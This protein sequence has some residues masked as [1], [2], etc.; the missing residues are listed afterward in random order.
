MDEAIG[1]FLNQ[2]VMFVVVIKA[3]MDKNTMG[4]FTFR[5][6]GRIGQHYMHQK[7]HQKMG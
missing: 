3:R 5:L 2:P 4:F 6:F 7:M 1:K